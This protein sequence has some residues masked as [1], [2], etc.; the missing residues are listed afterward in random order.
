MPT[1]TTVLKANFITTRQA[2][3]PPGTGRLDPEENAHRGDLFQPSATLARDKY[4]CWKTPHPTNPWQPDACHAGTLVASRVT[5]RSIHHG[6]GVCT[7]VPGVAGPAPHPG[8]R[9]KQLDHPFTM[10]KVCA[11]MAAKASQRD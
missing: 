6:E 4:M 3:R 2:C 8:T 7:D 9:E 1:Q 10:Q 5:R 11:M